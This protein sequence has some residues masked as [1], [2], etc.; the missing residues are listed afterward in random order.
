[1]KAL[2]VNASPHGETSHG[3]RLAIEMIRMLGKSAHGAVV[4]R[5]LASQPL[6]P[7]TQ[8]HAQ[9][10]TSREPDVAGSTCPSSSFARSK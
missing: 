7:I 10:I 6:S 5:D 8:E 3:Y 1:M 4:E 9:A 2:I